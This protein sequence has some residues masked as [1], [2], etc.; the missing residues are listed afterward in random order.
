MWV[1]KQVSLPG[2]L[3]N[4]SSL[5]DRYTSIAAIRLVRHLS[6]VNAYEVKVCIDVI[7]GKTV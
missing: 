2:R 7:A 6:L 5:Q 1:G 4:L 3:L